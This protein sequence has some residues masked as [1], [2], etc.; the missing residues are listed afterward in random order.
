MSQ[1]IEGQN[2]QV[3]VTLNRLRGLRVEHGYTQRDMAEYLGMSVTAY[4]QREQ[5]ICAF[6]LREAKQ[7][8]DLF[9][10]SIEQVFYAED[11]I[12]N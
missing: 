12:V 7:I 4:C 9:C 3:P 11:V 1:I 2:Q 6:R 5:G 8:A 10:R